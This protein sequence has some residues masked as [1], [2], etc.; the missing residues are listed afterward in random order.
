MGDRQC[1]IKGLLDGVAK[2]KHKA[3]KEGLAAVERGFALDSV[4][5]EGLSEKITFE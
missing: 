3:E 2:E 5:K 4:L 1:E